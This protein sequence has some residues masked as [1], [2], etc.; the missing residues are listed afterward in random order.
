MSAAA[1]DSAA[2]G[3]KACCADFYADDNVRRILGD[4]FHPGGEAL[5]RELLAAVHVGPADRLLDVA[6]G[7]GT[8]SVL[9]AVETGCRVTA[10][11]LSEKNLEHAAALARTRGV[12]ERVDVRP[13]DAERLPFP[14]ESFDVVLCEC[15]FCTFPDKTRAAAELARVLRPGG[16]L[17]LSDMVLDRD[18]FPAD[19]DTLLLRVACIADAIPGPAL[20]RQFA[21]TGFAGLELH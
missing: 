2:P 15:A 17:A 12:A 10:L 5:T 18:R 11:D 21:D 20:V 6:A 7:P 19:L 13:A 14:D 4:S 3:F 1:A 16:R 9:A 8:S